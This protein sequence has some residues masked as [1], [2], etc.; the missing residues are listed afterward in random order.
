[1]A[2]DYAAC[3]S[4]LEAAYDAVQGVT[5]ESLQSGVAPRFASA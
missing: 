5:L 1:M 3:R 2:L 4:E